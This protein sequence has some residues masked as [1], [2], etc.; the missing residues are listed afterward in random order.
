MNQISILGCGWLGLPLAEHLIK[1]QYQIKGST[2]SIQKLTN[3]SSKGVLGTVIVLKEENIEGDIVSFLEKSEILIIDIPPKLRGLVKENFVTKIAQL[4]PYIIQSEIKKVIFISSTSVYGD[5]NTIVTEMSATNPDTEAGIQLLEI[6][7]ELKSHTEFETTIIRFSGL[8]GDD[9]HPIKSLSGKTNIENP[10]A[11]VNLV[12]LNDCIGIIT[13]I[14]QGNIF[15]KT[16][17][18]AYPFHPS[19]INYY[20]TKAQS[21]GLPLPLFSG[22]KLSVGKT[23]SSEKLIK[24]LSYD[25]TTAI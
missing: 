23:I 16:Y 15:G 18:V 4:I 12:H 9:R 7:S 3:L 5:S 20:T 11:P 17:N 13:K 22:E 2:T 1:L 25:F 14:I 21:L 10:D 8:I 24:E 6:E 19:R